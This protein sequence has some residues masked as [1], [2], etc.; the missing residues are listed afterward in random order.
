MSCCISEFV[1]GSDM[2]SLAWP[3]LGFCNNK[4]IIS[5]P[6]PKQSLI[7]GAPILPVVWNGPPSRILE[8]PTSRILESLAS[9]IFESLASRILETLLASQIL[10][11]LASL[12]AFGPL[13]ILADAGF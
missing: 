3:G 12:S 1:D 13:M 10:E 7:R 6:L 2:I 5:A 8:T 9:Q 4:I 11:T